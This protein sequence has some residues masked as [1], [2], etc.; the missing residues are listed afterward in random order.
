MARLLRGLGSLAVLLLGTVG[1]PVALA[2]LGGNPL[3]EELTWGAVQRALFTP[4]DD[5]ILVGLITII[6]WLHNQ[7]R[8]FCGGGCCCDLTALIAI[9]VHGLRHRDHRDHRDQ[10]SGCES[11]R[12]IEAGEPDP[13]AML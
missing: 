5:M 7:R 1:V 8:W 10:Q 3:P 9:G 6:G 2:F 12:C 4:A 13:N 11:L